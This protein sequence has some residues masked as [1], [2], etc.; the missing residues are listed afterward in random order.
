MSAPDRDAADPCANDEPDWFRDHPLT[1]WADGLVPL[2][3]SNV[4]SF[5]DLFRLTGESQNL[6]E[7][8]LRLTQGFVVRPV[9]PET[10]EAAIDPETG[11]PYPIVTPLDV[12]PAMRIWGPAGNPGY[13]VN[14]G[15]DPTLPPPHW[16]RAEAGE[17]LLQYKSAPDAAF[18]IIEPWE[19][20]NR[21]AP[22]YLVADLIPDKQIVMLYG[23]SE[24]LKTFQLIDLLNSVATGLP[25][26][27]HFAIVR[28]GDAVLCLD[29]DPDD[30]MRGRYPAWCRARGIDPADW[31][32]RLPEGNAAVGRFAIIPRVPLV[33]LPSQ[34]DDLV[35]SIHTAGLRP[36]VIGID[37]AAKAMGGMEQNSAKDV[38]LLMAAATRLR[39]EFDCTVVIVHHVPKDGLDMRGSGAFVNDSD[40]GILSELTGRND[41]NVRVTVK[42]M[43]TDAKPP[44]FILQGELH[45]VGLLR[46]Y[47]ALVY[48]G[49]AA[50][51]PAPRDDGQ[52]DTVV[53]ALQVEQALRGLLSD[54]VRHVSTDALVLTLYPKG[55]DEEPEEH[56][57]RV[58]HLVSE[59]GR[60]ANDRA[61]A[62]RGRNGGCLAKFIMRSPQGD[63]YRPYRWHLPD[64]MREPAY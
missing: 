1:E 22:A 53:L 11:K 35:K 50:D 9:D 23:P 31:P 26:F 56:A 7:A 46:R 45:D 28:T 6:V 55:A 10:G 49:L 41:L 60:Y 33:G 58:K 16:P 21:P 51:H 14:A 37:T 61:Q 19:F 59:F 3:A 48:R 64:E 24:T 17:H 32:V 15:V 18:P 62:Y 12:T 42:R 39:R 8:M 27:G 63:Q 29:E 36:A 13:G 2:A 38:G 54:T 47:P 43:K 44:A 57:T 5:I 52:A 25:A 40:C 20:Q 30:A 34:V 4:W